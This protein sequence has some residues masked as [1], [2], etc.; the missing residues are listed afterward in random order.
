MLIKCLDC[1]SFIRAGLVRM[2]T[3]FYTPFF[4]CSKISPAFPLLCSFKFKP[5]SGLSG[6]CQAT[7][8]FLNIPGRFNPLDFAHIGF[9]MIQGGRTRWPCIFR[10]PF[11]CWACAPGLQRKA[12][13]Q[14]GARKHCCTLPD[15]A[16]TS[17][18]YLVVLR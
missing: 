17:A 8:P 16:R 15:G 6:Q 5:L 12:P 13:A 1:V 10:G 18:P 7:C 4:R 9:T 2:N 14:R 3:S 11:Q